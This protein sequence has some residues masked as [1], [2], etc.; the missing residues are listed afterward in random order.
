MSIAWQDCLEAALRSAAELDFLWQVNATMFMGLLAVYT[1]LLSRYSSAEHIVCGLPHA[2]RNR[3]ETEG[4]T[5]VVCHG[6][7]CLGLNLQPACMTLYAPA[8]TFM[9]TFQ[10]FRLSL[11]RL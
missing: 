2:G 9:C 3:A 11:R 8:F 5:P 10:G 7:G 6:E 1:V 4:D